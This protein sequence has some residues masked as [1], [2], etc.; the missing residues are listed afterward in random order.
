MG[1]EGLKDIADALKDDNIDSGVGSGFFNDFEDNQHG[2]TGIITA[3]LSAIQSITSKTCQPLQIPI[4]FTN[5]NVSLPCMTEVYNQ[6]I[7]TIYNIWK[8][9][10]FGIISYFICIDIF[11]IVKGFKDPES[12]KVEVLDL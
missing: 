7:P 10:S 8:V 2:L 1:K 9:V 3:P 6:R 12:D 5:K 4:P 11:H